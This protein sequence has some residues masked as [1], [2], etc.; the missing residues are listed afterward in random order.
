MLERNLI[1]R[2]LELQQGFL[3]ICVTIVLK[4]QLGT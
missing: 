3:L 1:K 2:I 4:N